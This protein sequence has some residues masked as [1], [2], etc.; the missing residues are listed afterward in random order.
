MPR[1]VVCHRRLAA[2]ALCP[3]DGARAPALA[4]EGYVGSRPPGYSQ[5]RVLGVGGFATTWSV[6]AE[7]GRQALKWARRS[8]AAAQQ[9]FAYEAQVLRALGGGQAPSLLDSGVLEGRPYLLME[10]IAGQ[11]LGA[12]LE[13]LPEPLSRPEFLR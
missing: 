13:S 10:E 12:T 3:A 2:E 1:C 4:V 6:D 8:S 9:R 5:A 7:G 11:T